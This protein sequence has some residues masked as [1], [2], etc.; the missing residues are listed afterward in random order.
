[1]LIP[2]R[3]RLKRHISSLRVS[4]SGEQTKE[5]DEGV[6]YR[7]LS[8]LQNFVVVGNRFINKS[9]YGKTANP[10]GMSQKP[11]F[12]VIARRNDEA[13]QL[14]SVISE[15]LHFVRNDEIGLSRHPRNVGRKIFR[16]RYGIPLGMIPVCRPADMSSSVDMPGVSQKACPVVIARRNDE[17][18]RLFSDISGLLH[19]VRNDESGLLRHPLIIRQL[20]NF[21][22]G[23]F[24]FQRTNKRNRRR[25]QIKFGRVRALRATPN[26][27]GRSLPSG[28]AFIGQCIRWGCL[29]STQPT[30]S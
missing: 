5:T 17:A 28:V 3:G 27:I 20:Q 23:S 9:I 1:M 15:L 18:I 30:P 24:Y 19:F 26:Q 8:G 4:I 10:T 25:R 11:R 16:I 29:E 14:L 7:F 2:F 13:I 12:F 6:G 22:S 21:V